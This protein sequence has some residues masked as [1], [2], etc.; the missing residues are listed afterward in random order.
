MKGASI[1]PSPPDPP[2]AS[3]IKAGDLLPCGCYYQCGCWVPPYVGCCTAAV[4]AMA[5]AFSFALGKSSGGALI[6]VGLAACWTLGIGLVVCAGATLAA[7]WSG[8][9][10]AAARLWRIGKVAFGIGLGTV[11]GF[12]VGLAFACL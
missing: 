4:V 1:D 9:Q 12:G 5:V 7:L 11:S 3:P 10:G 2:P 8:G 6:S